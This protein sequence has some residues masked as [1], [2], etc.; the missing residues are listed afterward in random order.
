MHRLADISLPSIDDERALFGDVDDQATLLR[1]QS[2]GAREL[3][4]KMGD[5]GPL[6]PAQPQH[7]F[8]RDG[9]R[10]P[11]IDATGAGDAFNAAYLAARLQGAIELDAARAGHALAVQVIGHRGA[12]LPR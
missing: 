8:L 1:L 10:V 2:Y 4:I 6:L 11:A 12:I 5:R 9:D 3:V 7:T